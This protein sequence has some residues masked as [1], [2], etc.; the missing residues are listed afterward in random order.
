MQI[1]VIS[2]GIFCLACGVLTAWELN[3][4]STLTVPVTENVASTTD[5][6]VLN[7]VA[8]KNKDPL[9]VF[10]E[11]PLF[12]PD[13]QPLDWAMINRTNEAEGQK[14]L[15]NIEKRYQLQGVT[16]SL[17]EQAALIFD[18]EKSETLTLN[19]NESLAGWTLKVVDNYSVT[20]AQQTRQFQLFLSP[21]EIS[22]KETTANELTVQQAKPV[23]AFKKA[24]DDD[25][26]H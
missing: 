9:T 5:S 15:S 20:F 22:S 25:P 21:T 19:I 7:S 4:T 14:T 24:P 16:I 8:K 6:P 10:A 2:A 12:R 26:Y 23:K 17:P 11:K 13:R 1:A 18:T 3:N